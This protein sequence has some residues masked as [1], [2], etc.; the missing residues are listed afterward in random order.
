MK[1]YVEFLRIGAIGEINQ[2]GSLIVDSDCD[3][4]V[5]TSPA[6]I[7]ALKENICRRNAF[8]TINQIFLGAV[9]P[10]KGG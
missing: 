1:V 10:M 9:I 5:I 6:E 8:P 2:H 4:F 7:E 3:D